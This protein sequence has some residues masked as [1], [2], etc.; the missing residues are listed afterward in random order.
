MHKFYGLTE[1]QMR[2]FMWLIG[3][4]SPSMIHKGKKRR[5]V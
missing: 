4:P 1:L 3:I 5:K 2:A